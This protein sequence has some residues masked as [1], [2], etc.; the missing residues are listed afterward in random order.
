M[1]RIRGVIFDL[2]GTIADTLPLCFAAFRRSLEPL[3][4]RFLSHEEIK[5]T[6]GPSEEGTVRAFAPERL[7]E[8]VA[9][10][11]RH[12]RELHWMC[13]APFQGIPELLQDLRAGGVR[14]AMVTGKG[15][16]SAH[17]SLEKFQF[18]DLFEHIETGSP[19]GN[20][21]EEGLARIL[22]DWHS[23]SREEV[24]YVGDSPSDITNCRAVQLPIAAACWAASTD[25]EEVRKREPDWLFH[26]IDAFS[27]WLLERI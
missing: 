6:F 23:F 15:E 4:G 24:I 20:I 3:V 12:Y 17:I 7:E 22:D 9:A 14:L 19:S 25:T 8:G 10:Y 21:K 27:D 26:Q 13:P 5:A 11:L 1:T 18:H 2:D 16:S